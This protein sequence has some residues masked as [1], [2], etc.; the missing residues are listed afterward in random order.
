M[1]RPMTPYT[2]GEL[3]GVSICVSDVPG[4]PRAVRVVSGLTTS[5]QLDVEP[6]DYTEGPRVTGFV[7][8]N[9]LSVTRANLG[10]YNNVT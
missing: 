7:I 1:Y 2:F 4:K 3:T 6:P 8:H 5:I 9:E 10:Q